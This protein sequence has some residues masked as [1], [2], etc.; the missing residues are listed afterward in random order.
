VNCAALPEGRL[1][2]EP[3][4]H[5]E[6]AFTGADRDRLGKF[7]LARHG[8]IFLDDI[9]AIPLRLQAKLLHV[10]Q[11]GE[12]ARAGGEKVVQSDVRV[13]AATSC[14]L[15]TAIRAGQFREDLYYRLN[16]ARFASRRCANAR[17]R[18]PC[19]PATSCA[20]T[21]HR[22]ARPRSHRRRCVSS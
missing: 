1:E 18:Y 9:G 13:V 21:P 17:T 2:S 19:W 5:E 7:E 12:F 15:E 8:T 6:G 16:V 4:G 11:D 3:F 20:S 10:L 14:N 22:A